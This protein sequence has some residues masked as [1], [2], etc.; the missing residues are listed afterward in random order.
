MNESPTLSPRTIRLGQIAIARSGDKGNHANL[1]V[2]AFQPQAYE[3]LLRELTS[4]RVA[5]FFR[6]LGADRVVRFELP[7]LKAFNF[8]LYNALAGG[9]SRSL[10][11]DSQGKLL[12][13][14]MLEL[15][16]PEP[17]NLAQMIDLPTSQK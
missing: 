9:A 10:R 14:A 8:L 4:H 5:E 1:G 2:V 17:E 6:P 16:L 7:N 15:P 11:C 13:T 12:G 3:F